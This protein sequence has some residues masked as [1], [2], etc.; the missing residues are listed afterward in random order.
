MGRIGAV[1]PISRARLFAR[2]KRGLGIK[3]LLIAGPS[4]GG[5]QRAAVCAGSCGN[6]LNDAIAAG[7]DVF[8]TGEV[9]HHDALKA[10]AAGMSVVCALHSNSERPVLRR[11]KLKLEEQAPKLKVQISPSDRDPFMVG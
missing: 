4:T 5:V 7:A 6:H 1:K 9:R 8:L 3:H 11:L 10:A 2:I